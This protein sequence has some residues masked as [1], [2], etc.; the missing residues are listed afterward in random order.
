MKDK[1]PAEDSHAAVKDTNM[2]L[3]QTIEFIH[4]N[5]RITQLTS[6]NSLSLFK[7]SL[8]FLNEHKRVAI[9]RLHLEKLREAR[10]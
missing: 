6:I 7:I 5:K 3:H 1:V 4:S 2:C 10:D 9:E 8:C